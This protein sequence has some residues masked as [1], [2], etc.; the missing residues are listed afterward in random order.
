MLQLGNQFGQ[1][2]AQPSMCRIVI[3]RRM[4]QQRYRD[5]IQVDR[6]RA[7]AQPKFSGKPP[8][9]ARP[10]G[11]DDGRVRHQRWHRE[12]PLRCGWS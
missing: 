2:V 9:Q 12:E 7:N 10:H 1:L 4:P 5:L 3:V 6:G 8:R 11:D